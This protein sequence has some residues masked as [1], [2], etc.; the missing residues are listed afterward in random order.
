MK[1]KTDKMKET[2]ILQNE[3]KETKPM[4]V[5]AITIVKEK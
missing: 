3:T 4:K 1:S 5:N 2:R